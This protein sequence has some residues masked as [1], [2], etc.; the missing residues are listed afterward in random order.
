[1]LSTAWRN[2]ISPPPRKFHVIS[3]AH[4]SMA[5]VFWDAEEILLPDYLE[6]DALSMELI[7]LN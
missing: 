1:M 7:M 5:T 3:L 4:K 2:A 6:H